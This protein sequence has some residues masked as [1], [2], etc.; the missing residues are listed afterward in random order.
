MAA[1][2]QDVIKNRNVAVANI[3]KEDYGFDKHED[4][5]FESVVLVKKSNG[6]GT[7]F[8]VTSDLVLTNYHVV[9]EQ[10]FVE[11]KKW[12]KTETFGKVVAKDV[13]LDLALVKVQDRGAPVI[14]YDRKDVSLG[15]DVEA[16]GHPEGIE[17][18][19]TRGII[20]SVRKARSVMGVQGKTSAFHS[21]GLSHQPR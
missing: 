19:L 5:R 16:I 10:K 1:I 9:G 13:R 11:L 15:T 8:Y 6:L 18:S 20:S 4:K 14:F 12:D 2:R 17:F 7:G 21:D 3:K